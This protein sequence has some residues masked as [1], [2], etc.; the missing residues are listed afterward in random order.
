M[1]FACLNKINKK[2]EVSETIENKKNNNILEI[3]KLA[4]VKTTIT[5]NIKSKNK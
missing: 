3:K 1:K 5:G 4:I 2:P